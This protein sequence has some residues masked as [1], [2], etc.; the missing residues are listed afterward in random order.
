MNK[1]QKDIDDLYKQMEE[2]KNNT[3]NMS[4][5]FT[6]LTKDYLGK[7]TQKKGYSRINEELRESDDY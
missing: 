5:Q 7:G 1:Q 4:K 2:M 3:Q 6:G